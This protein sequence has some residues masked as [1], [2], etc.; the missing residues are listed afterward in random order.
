MVLWMYLA[1]FACS[2]FETALAKL[3]SRSVTA[4][5]NAARPLYL[6]INGMTACGAF[7]IL[8]GFRLGVNLRTLAYSAV[9]SVVCIAA[10]LTS[11]A[12]YN[13]ASVSVVGVSRNSASVIFN[14]FLGILLFKEALALRGVFRILLLLAAIFILFFGEKGAEKRSAEGRPVRTLTAIPLIALSVLISGAVSVIS[15]LYAKDPGVCD[16]NSFFFFTNVVMVVFSGVWLLLSCRRNG[17]AVRSAAKALRVKDLAFYAGST[18]M[19]NI[20]SLLT[21]A[22]LAR[23]DVSVFT[24]INSSVAILCAVLV[25]LLFREKVSV[26][27]VLAAVLAGAAMFI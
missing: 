11:I 4:V 7:Y 18:V 3:I 13:Y 5:G 12:V 27:S 19:S 14:T 22:I 16:S 8:G 1:F 21:V 10:L 20:V 24:A 23:Q 15:K 9:F 25:S 17:E 6:L 26:W 2:V